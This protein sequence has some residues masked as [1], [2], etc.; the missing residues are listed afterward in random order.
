MKKQRANRTPPRRKRIA[1]PQR[2]GTASLD[3]WEV[4]Q[5][6]VDYNLAAI[7]RDPRL[8]LDAVE[9]PQALQHLNLSRMTAEERAD[10][11]R[12]VDRNGQRDPD[13]EA[14]W[15]HILALYHRPLD[16]SIDRI[17]ET[18]HAM[19]RERERTWQG[20]LADDVMA[21]IGVTRSLVKEWLN[22]EERGIYEEAERAADAEAAQPGFDP[23]GH[24][25]AS[26][27][28]H[29]LLDHYIKHRVPIKV[30]EKAL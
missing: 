4:D 9:V 7:I 20:S 16:V 17:A 25:P 3:R 6:V 30:I 5:G 21:C 13:E 8:E 26:Q 22:A 18:T 2:P 28:L 24:L 10:F 19:W 12:L 23:R 14:R 29:A 27:R 15:Q 11:E 1:G